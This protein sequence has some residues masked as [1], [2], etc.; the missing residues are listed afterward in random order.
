M[1]LQDYLTDPCRASS[2]PYW[3]ACSVTVPAHITV[4]RD[5]E[6][7][8]AEYPGADERYFKLLHELKNVPEAVLPAGFALVSADVDEFAR[9]INACYE[10]EGVSAE[11]LLRC[12]VRRV[13]RPELWLAVADEASGNVVASAIAELDGSIGEGVLEWIQVSPAYRRRGLGAF[14]VCE[15]L[16]RLQGR[17][18]FVTVSGRMDSESR[19]FALYKGCGFT[20]EVIWHVIT[21]R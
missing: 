3:K 11:E 14:L 18:R 17:A 5:D 19:P 13:Y 16:R 4:V 8:A 21:K 9:H 1:N 15:L 2:L 10:R 20:N 6:F 12:Q 7:S